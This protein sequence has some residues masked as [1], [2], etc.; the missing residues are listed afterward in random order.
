MQER[1]AQLA[2]AQESE[3][4]RERERERQEREDQD[5]DLERALR[6]RFPRCDDC[7]A[8]HAHD[9]LHTRHAWGVS[10]AALPCELWLSRKNYHSNERAELYKLLCDR[11]PN[12]TY[13]FVSQQDLH[14]Y[15]QQQ[16]G[17]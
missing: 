14:K 6:S 7:P 2:L 4:E 1:A 12:H 5:T 13:G 9:N 10:L 8:C 11:R 17:E 3:R 16:Q 15:I